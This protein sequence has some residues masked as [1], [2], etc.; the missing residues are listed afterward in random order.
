[1]ENPK[2]LR[3]VIFT[4]ILLGFAFLFYDSPYMFHA[5]TVVLILIAIVV[6]GFVAVYARRNWRANPY[7]RALMYSKVS[8]GIIVNLS[9]VTSLLGPDWEWRA[10]VRFVCFALILVAQAR[11]LQLLFTT[12]HVPSRDDPKEVK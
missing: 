11:L 12:K 10:S 2:I 8:L 3:N 9:L 1:M 5:S 7:G 6:N 4:I